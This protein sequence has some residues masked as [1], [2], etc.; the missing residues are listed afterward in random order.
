MMPAD[1]SPGLGPYRPGRR[2]LSRRTLLSGALAGAGLLGA[3]GLS[4][5]GNPLA[6]AADGTLIRFWNLLSGGD[7]VLLQELL[8]I[9]RGEMPRADIRNIT[10]AWGA[11]YYT[12][13]AMASAGGRGPEV[14]ILHMARLPGYAPGGLLDPWDM[15]LLAEYEVTPGQFTDAVWERTQYQGQTYAIPLDTH[16]FVLFYNTDI[17][18]QAGLLGPDGRLVEITSP[19]EFLEAGRAMQ[20]ITGEYGLS[21]G[22]RNDVAQAWRGFF[23]FYRQ[24]GAELD[25]SG[26]EVQLNRG[27][28]VRVV[29][30]LQAIFDGTVANPNDDIDAGIAAFV[31]G[32]TGMLFSGDWEVPTMQDA[33]LPFDVAPIPTVFEEPAAYADSHSFVLPTQL[34]VDEERRRTTHEF[35]GRMLQNSLLWAEA[36]HIPAYQPVVESVEYQELVPQAHYAEVAGYVVFDPA[37]WFTGSGSNFQNRMSQIL[38]S[39]IIEGVEAEQ[40]V[41]LM[42]AEMN[43]FL[44]TPNPA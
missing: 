39:A 22:T 6:Q 11:P 10:L 18:E 28:A 36:G 30:F 17:A 1:P 34:A 13:L 41:D 40:V 43:T 33:G 37:A 21:Y 38:Q 12:K 31:A 20:Q 32:R 25:L 23:T 15:D 42:V 35:V 7:G 16:P 26:E 44:A 5:C 9:V 4:G 2:G 14:A 3:G 24:T 27:A 29:E 8:D 19:E